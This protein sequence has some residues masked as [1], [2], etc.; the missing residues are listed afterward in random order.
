MTHKENLGKNTDG[1]WSK[2]AVTYQI[3]PISFKDSN[4]D[5]KG[6]L[7]GIIEKIDYLNGSENSLGI[8][9]VWICPFY[10][11]PMLDFGYDI[12][13]F[14]DID[15]I[16]GG[17]PN[18][19]QLVEE[20]H[21]RDIKLIID[22][23][24]NHTS[25]RHKWFTESRSSRD[26]PKRDWYVWRDGVN[27]GPPNNWISV[28]G[29]S[30]WEL[31]TSTHQ[32][33]LHSFLKEQPDLNWRNPEV[34]EAMSAVIDFWVGKGVDGLRIDAFLHFIE[35]KLL[36]EDPVNVFYNKKGDD[37]YN[38][39]V[40]VHS[41]GDLDQTGLLGD[42]IKETLERH[43]DIMIVGEAYLDPKGIH[44][45]QNAYSSDRFTIF[46]FN[47]INKKWSAPEYKKIIDEYLL[48]I[49]AHFLPNFVFGNHDVDRVASRIGEAE[50]RMA[51]FLQ[52]T[53]P[54][55]PFIYYGDEIGMTNTKIPHDALKDIVAKI[56]SGYH[57]G[58]DPE[59]TPMQWDETPYG[60]FS[61]HRPWLP[62]NDNYKTVNVEHEQH[63]EQSVLSFYKKI[64]RLR[65]EHEI[66]RAGE[67]I[68]VNSNASNILSFERRLGNKRYFISINFGANI[69]REL[70]PPYTKKPQIVFS[71]ASR[72]SSPISNQVLE[73]MP[74]EGYVLTLESGE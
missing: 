2:N 69:E 61:S 33:Y 68:P 16:F 35:D 38:A 7:A 20:L 30:A 44:T 26:N 74:F 48:G 62:V 52:F 8:N 54:G 31:D 4:G 53:L 34:R 29:G 67:Y 51:A 56:F 46:N 11:S 13:D 64:I 49:P 22:F 63:D 25:D 41:V 50:A 19:D 5:G 72:F 9:A 27:D 45:L 73:L 70:L 24:G 65:K 57:G 32:Y 36:R 43:K 55:M 58:R 40:H 6:D 60:G 14:M 42:F 47:F 15:P 21:K 39:L 10:R 28:F 17:M 37:P 59:R 1:H 23:V 3:Y 71:T 12:E 66:L 18:F